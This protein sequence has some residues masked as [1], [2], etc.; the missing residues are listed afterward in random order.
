MED[1]RIL[2]AAV[3]LQFSFLTSASQAPTPPLPQGRRK[4]GEGRIF[5]VCVCA[6]LFTSA[7]GHMLAALLLMNHM[8]CRHRGQQVPHLD[9]TVWQARSFNPFTPEAVKVTSA[10]KLAHKV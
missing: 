2:L 6:E 10:M 3:M 7:G 4:R 5:Y 8:H 9:C 1:E